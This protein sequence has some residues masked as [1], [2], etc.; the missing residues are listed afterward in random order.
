[1]TLSQLKEALNNLQTLADFELM[2]VGAQIKQQPFSLKQAAAFT[3]WR[4]E[5]ERRNIKRDPKKYA[6][7]YGAAALTVLGISSL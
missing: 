4:A 7:G 6:A 3:L 5:V 1:M 2:A